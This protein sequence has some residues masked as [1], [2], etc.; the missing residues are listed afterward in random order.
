MDRPVF[1][2]LV[3]LACGLVSV[4][5]VLVTGQPAVLFPAPAGTGTSGT[6]ERA[7]AEPALRDH[8][9]SCSPIAITQTDGKTIPFPCRP[10]RIIAANAN[11]AE[12][13]IALGASDRIVGATDSTLAVPYIREKIPHASSIGD[14]QTPNVE[15]IL[16]LHPDAVIAYSSYRP[17]NADQIE[18]HNITIVSLDCYRL[19]T[20][21]S[22]ARALGNLTGTQAAAETYARTVE[23][24]ISSVSLRA[25]KVP[26]GPGPSVY[27][28]SY[29]DL[30][31]SAPGSAADEIVTGAGG[32]NIADETISLSAKVSPEWVVSKQP[33]FI[34]KAVS[35]SGT[36]S[37]AEVRSD[38]GSRA[39]WQEIPAVHNGRVYTFSNEILYGPRA[40]IGLVHAARILHPDEFADL[41]PEEML[42]AYNRT[43]VPGTSRAGLIC[44]EAGPVT[45][46]RD[47]P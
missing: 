1:V 11:A 4:A 41:D 46:N 15:Q 23:N 6:P 14:W 8:P 47:S 31:V 22:D 34:F 27:V 40:Y 9:V 16:S 5:A 29:T 42:D 26:S 30:M 12:L 45:E 21:A 35:S 33:A 36:R 18:A 38:I 39:G 37:L 19:S 3:L 17:K 24:T 20:L 10:E 44:P 32:E 2:L 7:A 25:S 28:E 13:L 43:Y